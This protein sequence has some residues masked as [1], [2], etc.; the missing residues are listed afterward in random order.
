MG[1]AIRSNGPMTKHRHIY[2]KYS[3]M[4]IWIVRAG[5]RSLK[6]GVHL[7]AVLDVS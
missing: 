5:P 4:K 2:I 3:D 1:F 7:V 6:N